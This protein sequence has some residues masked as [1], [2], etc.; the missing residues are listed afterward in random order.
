MNAQDDERSIVAL[1]ASQMYSD[2]QQIWPTYDR[3]HLHVREQIESFVQKH[4][5]NWLVTAP[6]VLDVGCGK[7][8]Y[9][10]LPVHTIGLDKFF[11]QVA[12]RERAVVGDIEALPF[13]AGSFDV[14]IC[15]GS[16]INYASALEA[17]S[18][19]ARVLAKG[20]RLVLHFESSA[21]FELFA[22]PPWNALAYLNSCENSYRN[23]H[24]WVY[25]PR[26]IRKALTM[27]G[28]RIIA[29]GHFHILPALLV[30]FGVSQ[31]SA[32]ALAKFDRLFGWLSAFADNVILL[33]EK[34]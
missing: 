12:G 34:T 20:G 1:S 30:R 6:T 26:L 13:R 24:I 17:I 16:V 27:A 28:F 15:V 31:T 22:K 29:E 9:S 25:A 10:W 11:E 5:L 7:D 21:S 2:G 18:E 32:A 4:C 14:V 8:G 23:D 19:L 33:A 3:W